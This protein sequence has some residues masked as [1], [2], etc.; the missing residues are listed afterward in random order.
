MADHPWSR[1]R[2]ALGAIS[3][4]LDKP[5]RFSRTTATA[6]TMRRLVFADGL[7]CVRAALVGGVRLACV[8][9]HAKEIGRSQDSAWR[10]AFAFRAILRCVAFGHRPHVRERAAIATNIIVN[11]HF[12]SPPST[13]HK[14]TRNPRRMRGSQ[15]EGRPA[16]RRAGRLYVWSK[17]LPENRLPLFRIMLICPARAASGCR[18]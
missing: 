13:S 18:P 11:W 10:R 12:I 8:R 3:G 4:F 16:S 1:S 15:P 14:R 6:R 17:I 5:R 9:G 7:G 2:K